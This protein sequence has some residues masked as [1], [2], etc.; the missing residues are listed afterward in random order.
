MGGAGVKTTPIRRKICFAERDLKGSRLRCLLLTS[1]SRSTVRA[2]VQDL[3]GPHA[4]LGEDAVWMPR[5]LLLSGEP[6]LGKSLE[7]LNRE[8]REAITSWWLKNPRGA[9]TPTW[10]L[11]SEC[12][13]DGKRG[14]ILVE[15]KAHAG[16]LGWED[17]CKSE[18]EENRQQI[19]NALEAANSGLNK[20]V[21]GWRL[22]RD[23]HYQLS[24][25]FA[26]AW[27]VASLGLPV[28]LVYLGF[29]DAW[30]MN[31]GKRTTLTSD[32]QWRE[33][34]LAYAKGTVP[35][36]IW[37]SRRLVNETPLISLIRSAR[38]EVSA[39]CRGLVK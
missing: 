11:V 35:E 25:R 29:L 31:D 5:G 34:L 26:F 13:V 33:C 19:A 8:Q 37:E 2:F 12:A 1:K 21:P 15:A 3:I 23:S 16:E 36:S 9:R 27:K 17:S 32:E 20:I 6:R 14:L 38:V 18:D 39:N 4:T 28:V 22:K 24:N 10:D 7:F 30:D